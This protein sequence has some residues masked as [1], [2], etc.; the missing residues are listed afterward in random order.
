[1]IDVEK[2]LEDLS[3]QLSTLISDTAKDKQYTEHDLDACRENTAK[4]QRSADDNRTSIEETKGLQIETEQ[5]ITDMDLQNI[6][7][8]QMITDMDLRILELEGKNE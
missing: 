5:T 1:M 6:E 2:K 8:E 3:N 4:I 7:A